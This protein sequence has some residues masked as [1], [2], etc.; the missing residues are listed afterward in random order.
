MKNLTIKFAFIITLLINSAWVSSA[1]ANGIC[2]SA[3][4][5]FNHVVFTATEKRKSGA[6]AAGISGVTQHIT[7]ES[8]VETFIDITQEIKDRLQ[9]QGLFTPEN[10]GITIDIQDVSHHTEKM[11]EIED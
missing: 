7:I 5:H 2:P 10:G 6:L 4:F 9:T 11:C 3:I 1:H 8:D